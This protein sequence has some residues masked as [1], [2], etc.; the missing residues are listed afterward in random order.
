M[1]QKSL[2]EEISQWNEEMCQKEL[3]C[4]LPKLVS[5]YQ[6]SDSWSEHIRVLKILTEMFM[7]HI[8]VAEIGTFLSQ[9]LPKAV[10]FF[11]EL[12]DELSSQAEGLSSQNADLCTSF[13]NILQT[14]VQ[15][16]GILTG[17]VRNISAL[18]ETMAMENIHSLPFSVVHV[19]KSTFTHCKDIETVYSG[20][21][22]LVSDLLQSLFR[23]AYSLQKQLMEL[24]DRIVLELT[25]PEEEIVGMVTGKNSSPK[26]KFII[27]SRGPFSF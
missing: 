15:L 12:M 7:P 5:M 1:S 3:E 22:H 18:E 27:C 13:R 16:L 21:L 25:A 20:R 8:S 17:C 14:M 26:C 4:V 24:L 10:K 6:C 9:V 23:E 11:D 19:L 2:L